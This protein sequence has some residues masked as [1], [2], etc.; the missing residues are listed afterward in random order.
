M[1]E[2]KREREVTAGFGISNMDYKKKG[3]MRGKYKQRN[4]FFKT[5]YHQKNE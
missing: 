4:R 2:G 3:A 5:S 1:W